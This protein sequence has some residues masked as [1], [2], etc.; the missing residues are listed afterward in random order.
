MFAV[1]C[2][3]IGYLLGALRHINSPTNNAP[4]RKKDSGSMV[5]KM[6]FWSTIRNLNVS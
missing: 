4:Y 1:H 3:V 5:S 6:Q 2:I